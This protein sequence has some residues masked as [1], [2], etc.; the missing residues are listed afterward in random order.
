VLL[1]LDI[2][3]FQLHVRLLSLLHLGC[4]DDSVL[5]RVLRMYI[6]SCDIG[7]MNNNHTYKPNNTQKL[8]DKNRTGGWPFQFYFRRS[9]KYNDFNPNHRLSYPQEI[10]GNLMSKQSHRYAIDDSMKRG[11]GENYPS[12]LNPFHFNLGF[13]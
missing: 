4:I 6:S 1:D 8:S 2:G 7:Y 10:M 5:T 9:H 11:S 13:Q 3:R 12:N